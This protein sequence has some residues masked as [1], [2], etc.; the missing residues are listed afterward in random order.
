MYVL[1]N[2]YVH[3][4]LQN[5]TRF[6]SFEM[7]DL[8]MRLPAV[9]KLPT[10]PRG[11]VDSGRLGTVEAPSMSGLSHSTSESYSIVP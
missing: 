6:E 1:V 3:T 9:S 2:T 7:M 10:A 8:L 5:N 11:K 4:R